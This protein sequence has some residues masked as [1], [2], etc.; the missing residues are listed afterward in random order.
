MRKLLLIPIVFFLACSDE[1]T[2]T[3]QITQQTITTGESPSFSVKDFGAKGD[4]VADDTKAFQDAVNAAIEAGG[5]EL[6]VPIAEK[7]YNIKNTI[8]IVPAAGDPQCYL[9]INA[10]G[11]TGTQIRYNGPNNTAVFKVI[12][13]KS[14]I[15]SGL[16]VWVVPGVSGV[17]VWDIDTTPEYASTSLVTFKNCNALLG[18][19]V[20]NVGWRL[21]H[22]SG[23]GADISNYVWENCAAYGNEPEQTVVAG[24]IG[25]LSE[26]RNTLLN[27]WFGGFGAYLDKIFSNASTPG[28]GAK[29]ENGNG[30]VFFYGLG[31]SHNNIDFEFHAEQV[32]YITGGRFEVGKKF[33]VVRDGVEDPII[34]VTGCEVEDYTSA[35]GNLIH[36][37]R[38]GSLTL[39]G[40]R[41]IAK[42]GDFTNM[43]TLGGERGLGRLI[44]RGGSYTSPKP[45]YKIVKG[46]WQ[47][48]IQSVG[49]LNGPY[50]TE[51][52]ENEPPLN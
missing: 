11:V 26:G 5:A 49:K 35:D 40:C 34:T 3:E 9:N 16:K 48:N 45:F 22:L 18:N 10:Y 38:P 13:L 39:D 51:F 31:G 29:T 27:S 42:G 1:I 33:L 7:Y 23:G 46:T 44:V 25:W 32:Y 37:G 6:I 30:S 14:S 8:N 12:G 17:V 15:I 47:V 24:Q 41:M 4:G 2:Y 52:F 43:I 50:A 21:G 36:M 28:T 19:G 20:N